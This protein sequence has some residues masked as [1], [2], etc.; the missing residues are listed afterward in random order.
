MNKSGGFSLIEL[1][2][3]LLVLAVIMSVAVPVLG[4]FWSNY[5]L[6]ATAFLLQEDIRALG[7][8]AL[9][10]EYEGFRINLYALDDKYQIYDVASDTLRKVERFPPG[11]DLVSSSFTNDIIFFKVTGRPTQGGHILLRCNRT[12][13]CK[14]VIVTPITGRIR[15]SDQPPVQSQ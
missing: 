11:I 4:Y 10:K 14:Y 15:V 12:G 7:Q 5:Q 3:V 13:K 2:V 8:E 1:M 9:V 6:G